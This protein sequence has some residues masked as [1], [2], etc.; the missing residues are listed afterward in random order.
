MPCTVLRDVATGRRPRAGDERRI[1]VGEAAVEVD[2]GARKQ[3]LEQRRTVPRRA[4][5]QARDV[6]VLGPPHLGARRRV[7]EVPGI[8]LAAV[9]RIE[10]QRNRRG[11][12]A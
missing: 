5:V 11:T 3:R 7:V 8:I 4:R 9:R 6:R 2:V 1:D 12:G 10:Y